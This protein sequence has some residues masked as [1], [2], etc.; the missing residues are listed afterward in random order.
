M[1][2][3]KKIAFI[4]CIVENQYYKEC[5]KYLADLMVPEGYCT[6]I[7]SVTNVASMTEG[8]NEAMQAS[9]A[10]Y[11]VYLREDIFLLNRNF[12]ADVLN[13][14]KSNAQIG[15]IGVRGT[16]RLPED[17]DCNAA[18]NIGNIREYDGSCLLY[19]SPS[20]RDS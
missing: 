3:R 10:K 12:I 13:I 5:V 2:E 18:W 11:K 15:M 1:D 14:F 19:T 20:P 17:A 16:D 6:D 4:V 8:Y 7:L 9:D